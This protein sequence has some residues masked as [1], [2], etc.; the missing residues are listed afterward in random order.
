M[1][2]MKNQNIKTGAWK[3]YVTGWTLSV[4]I[5]LIT[6]I[7]N[8]NLPGYGQLDDILP[9]LTSS[10]IW[11]SYYT[12]LF[13]FY[14]IIASIVVFSTIWLKDILGKWQYKLML[15]FSF[16]SFIRIFVWSL[17]LNS[18]PDVSV[19]SLLYTPIMMIY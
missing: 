13:S 18:Y 12:I 7:T 4:S 10:E 2:E 1:E 11:Q 14:I 15:S 3:R 6:L 5:L 8:Y 9:S 16:I 17:E 19:L